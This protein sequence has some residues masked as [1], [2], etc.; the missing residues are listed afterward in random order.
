MTKKF[1]I[2]AAALSVFAAPAF[3]KNYRFDLDG[4][5]CDAD[6]GYAEFG[7]EGMA[8]ID[9]GGQFLPNGSW[10]IT[11]QKDIGK[12]FI[13]YSLTSVDTGW[14]TK[15]YLRPS[16]GHFFESPGYLKDLSVLDQEGYVDIGQ[17]D[18]CK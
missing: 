16:T 4:G 15:V 13:E 18:P 3:A 7:P 11:D 12:G 8:W 6:E 5:K 1:L 14:K 9:Y 17:L 2:A 10:Y